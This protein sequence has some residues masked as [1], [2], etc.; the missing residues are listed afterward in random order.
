MKFSTITLHLLL[1]ALLLTL[2]SK[3]TKGQIKSPLFSISGKVTDSVTRQTVLP[4]I[5]RLIR[6]AK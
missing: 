5:Y 2:L 1:T 4:I 3:Q 6:K